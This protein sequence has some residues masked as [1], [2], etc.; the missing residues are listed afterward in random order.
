MSVVIEA[1]PQINARCWFQWGKEWNVERDPGQL[2]EYQRR[3]RAAR[4]RVPF[5]GP[6]DTTRTSESETPR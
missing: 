6:Q 5:V 2:A 1:M 4:Y 3:L